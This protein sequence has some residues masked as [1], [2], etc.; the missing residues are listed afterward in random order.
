MYHGGSQEPMQ[1]YPSDSHR[2]RQ[3]GLHQV[4]ER[5]ERILETAQSLFLSDGLEQTSMRQIADASGIAAVTLYRYF[6][7]RHPIAIEIAARM[8]K[9]IF[10]VCSEAA[11]PEADAALAELNDER[12]RRETFCRYCLAMVDNYRRLRDAYRYIG[13]FD[14]LYRESYTSREL[15]VLYRRRLREA[16]S[17]MPALD[18]HEGPP[19][20]EYD[21][22]RMVTLSNVI[23]S[24][25]QKMATRGEMMGREQ[26]VRF[27]VQM[28]HFR[29]YLESILVSEFGWEPETRSCP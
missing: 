4:D 17:G 28:R 21:R 7:D 26:R 13:T 8:I 14:N 24:Y 27:R 2:R 19:E 22:G 25:M 23:M 6:P 10:D 18:L 16:V 15:A 3:N 9:Q 29:T 12:Y 20:A 5:R 1:S 11:R